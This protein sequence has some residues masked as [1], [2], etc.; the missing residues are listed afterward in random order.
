MDIGFGYKLEWF[1]SGNREEKT[2][3]VG[4]DAGAEVDVGVGGC[5]SSRLINQHSFLED[6]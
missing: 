2:E 4:T 1:F 3:H 6:P 5:G